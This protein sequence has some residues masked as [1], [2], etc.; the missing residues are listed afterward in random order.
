[1]PPEPTAVRTTSSPGDETQIA[2]FVSPRAADWRF[3]LPRSG[4]EPFRRLT[5]VGASA[6]IVAATR[7]LGIAKNVREELPNGDSEPSDALVVFRGTPVDASRLVAALAD[8]G[9]AFIEIDRRTSAGVLWPPRR[10]TRALEAGGLR[11]AG[12]YAVIAEGDGPRIYVPLLARHAFRW[13]ADLRARTPGRSAAVFMRLVRT[14]IGLDGHQ[15]G[16]IVPRFALVAV[17]GSANALPSV[18]DSRVVASTIDADARYPILLMGGGDRV[19]ALPFTTNGGEPVAVIKAPRSSRFH[20]RSENDQATLVTLQHALSAGLRA[21]IPRPLGIDHPAPGELLT[22]E[23]LVD[24]ESLHR[25]CG[26][27]GATQAIRTARLGDAADWLAKFHAETVRGRLEW[28]E[29]R[30]SLLQEPFDD[31]MRTFGSTPDDDQLFARALAYGD[32]LDGVAVPIVLQHRDFNLWNL[33][34]SE[35]G[36]GVVDWEGAR[37]GPALTDLLHLVINWHDAVH[38]AEKESDKPRLFQRLFMNPDRPHDAYAVAAHQVI[39]AY[40]ARLRM[41]RRVVPLLLLNMWVELAL[42]RA[43]QRRDLG[44]PRATDRRGNR[45]F[46]FV[47][48]M[49]QEFDLLVAAWSAAM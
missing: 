2:E 42:R 38:G 35:R 33:L 7:S 14:A 37:D 20:S 27:R 21:A 45:A 6:G 10:L 22:V 3:L 23:S 18:L 15:L 47:A 8:N 26:T 40:L 39:A 29:F 24:G 41:D 36:L 28:P 48:W 31:Y 30:R 12:S 43:H 4:T 13:Y 32:H 17:R 9:T 11:I 19:V 1:M 44:D 25:I 46:P 34:W 49:A 16:G 5:L